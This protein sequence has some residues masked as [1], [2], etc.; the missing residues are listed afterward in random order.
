MPFVAGPSF[1]PRCLIDA[2]IAA[3]LIRGTITFVLAIMGRSTSIVTPVLAVTI[4]LVLLA[5][6]VQLGIPISLALAVHAIDV[7]YLAVVP[8][9]LRLEPETVIRSLALA[10]ATSWVTWW[11]ASGR[12]IP[13]PG[14]GIRLA[15][16]VFA[17]VGVFAVVAP[18]PAL[19]HDP[20]QG[21]VVGTA[22]FNVV[23]D[24]RTATVRAE[25][26]GLDCIGVTDAY[27]V[28]RRAGSVSRSRAS[29][30]GCELSSTVA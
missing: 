16:M 22:R 28:A 26:S 10:V 23:S 7:P 25:L 12:W 8:G 14:I 5:R 20:G 19:A 13:Q 24:G 15:L 9:G 29:R 4:A 21:T 30:A 18:T 2:A 6:I 1:D 3:T 27:V 11:L 17:V